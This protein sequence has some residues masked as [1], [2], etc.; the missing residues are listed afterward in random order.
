ME[1]TENTD[2]DEIEIELE[3]EEENESS[4]HNYNLRR[5]SGGGSSS[6]SSVNRS[7]LNRIPGMPGIIARLIQAVTNGEEVSADSSDDSDFDPENEAEPAFFW[8]STRRRT[9]PKEKS[10]PKPKP[11]WVE[12]LKSSDFYQ[13]TEFGLGEDLTKC[14][15]FS[16]KSNILNVIHNREV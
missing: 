13:E 14:H 1:A 2:S 7:R 12:N 11:E 9:A 8:P 6:E 5:R 15:R 4:N 3:T 10:P 16:V